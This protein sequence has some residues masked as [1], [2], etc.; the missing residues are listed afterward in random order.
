MPS[1]SV[2]R[3]F[4]FVTLLSFASSAFGN[5]RSGY[6]LLKDVQSS[7]RPPSLGQFDYTAE[8][9]RAEIVEDIKSERGAFIEVPV[10]YSR[11]ERGKTQIYYRFARPFDPKKPTLIEFDGG[12]GS[13]SHNGDDP[14]IGA[15]ANHLR[16]DSRGVAFS[17]PASE[18]LY[19]DPTFYSFQN[20]ARD[21]LEIVNH[22][23]IKSAIVWGGS[24]GAVPAFEFARLDPKRFHTVILHSPSNPHD[25][26]LIRSQFLARLVKTFS[27]ESPE[28]WPFFEAASLVAKD[29]DEWLPILVY[30]SVRR[31]GIRNGFNFLKSTLTNMNKSWRSGVPAAG[32]IGSNDHDGYLSVANDL[33]EEVLVFDRFVQHLLVRKEMG[34]PRHSVSWSRQ[35]GAQVISHSD[36]DVYGQFGLENIEVGT[37][38]TYTRK[39]PT[40]EKVYVIAGTDDMQTPFDSVRN[41]FESIE[42]DRKTFLKID[43]GRH[44]DSGSEYCGHGPLS[45]WKETARISF[46]RS[47][48]TG[49]KISQFD[50]WKF[51]STGSKKISVETSSK[52]PMTCTGWLNLALLEKWR[53]KAFKANDTLRD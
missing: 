50:I 23:K 22:L 34:S 12:P 29:K 16:F 44:C 13:S 46:W 39:G 41:V 7:I 20:T 25:G 52:K 32:V 37:N 2:L 43:G 42:S 24:A 14:I 1:Q 11:P 38:D 53:S 19:R 51:N 9:I 10:D 6:D 36:R 40:P 28:L 4:L 30:Q 26:D 45:K 15:F 33:Y 17:R 21:A 47:I 5:Y 27:D 3:L 18:E 8:S 31:F 48:L 49:T 35:N